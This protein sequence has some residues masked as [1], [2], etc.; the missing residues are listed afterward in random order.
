MVLNFNTNQS[1]L[2]AGHK[3]ETLTTPLRCYKREKKML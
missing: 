3:G 1:L 2:I